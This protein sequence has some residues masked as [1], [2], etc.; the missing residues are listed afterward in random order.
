MPIALLRESCEA[1]AAPI[2]RFPPFAIIAPPSESLWA[3]TVAKRSGCDL[4]S[5]GHA[6]GRRHVSIGQ[7]QS[8]MMPH[9]I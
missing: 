1:R 3:A 8:D 2:L 4:R 6:A 5:S 9:A 7:R